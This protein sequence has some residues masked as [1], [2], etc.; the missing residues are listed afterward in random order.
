MN[1]ISQHVLA[2]CLETMHRVDVRSMAALH[3]AAEM[4][5]ADENHEL[6]QRASHIAALLVAMELEALALAVEGGCVVCP[7]CQRRAIEPLRE[8]FAPWWDEAIIRRQ[9]YLLAELE[10]LLPD[11][12][13]DCTGEDGVG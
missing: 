1:A 8:A 7:D 5:R 3:S 9:D 4:A 11:E 12:A 6:G 2:N 10:R 13:I